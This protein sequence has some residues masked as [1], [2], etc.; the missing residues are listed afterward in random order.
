M[1]MR[2]GS[3]MDSKEHRIIIGEH[4]IKVDH[5]QETSLERKINGCIKSIKE[6]IKIGKFIERKINGKILKNVDEKIQAAVNPKKMDES[7]EIDLKE[8]SVSYSYQL[9]TLN[10]III[11]VKHAFHLLETKSKEEGKPLNTSGIFREDVKTNLPEL[12]AEIQSIENSDSHEEFKKIFADKNPKEIGTILKNVVK[13]TQILVE[14]VT[15]KLEQLFIRTLINIPKVK[16]LPN[17]LKLLEHMLHPEENALKD[18]PGG[19]EFEKDLRKICL[20]N[21]EEIKSSLLDSLR[22]ELPPE[23]FNALQNLLEYLGEVIVRDQDHRSSESLSSLNSM[24]IGFLF[25][26]SLMPKQVPTS[27]GEK[28]EFMAKC[29]VHQMMVGSLLEAECVKIRKGRAEAES[30]HAH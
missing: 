25:H 9:S 10:D 18:W 17:A 13:N 7:T 6:N 8:K 23:N 12:L 4:K 11:E 16:E 27:D 22:R 29:M 19:F 2:I 26:Q 20:E 30:S 14:G 3:V 21:S 24:G 28:K 1:S 15:D 5:H